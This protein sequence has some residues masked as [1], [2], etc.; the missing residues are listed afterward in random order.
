MDGTNA[1]TGVEHEILKVYTLEE[2]LKHRWCSK[3]GGLGVII[4]PEKF[5]IY[6]LWNAIS[7]ISAR[8]FQEINMKENASGVGRATFLFLTTLFKVS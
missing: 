3:Q 6:S 5:Q 2:K 1:K 7:C 4:P 8:H